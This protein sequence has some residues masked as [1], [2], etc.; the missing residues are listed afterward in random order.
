M[1]I[2]AK[3]EKK[4]RHFATFCQTFLNDDRQDYV[5]TTSVADP[6]PFISGS[7]PPEPDHVF[8]A[9]ILTQNRHD[10]DPNIS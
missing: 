6:G 5:Y 8:G 9:L 1:Q 2:R 7:C 3:F 4:K 10:F